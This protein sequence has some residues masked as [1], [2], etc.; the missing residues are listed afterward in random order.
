MSRPTISLAVI[1][2]DCA[3]D[4]KRM[5]DSVYEH[6]DQLVVVVDSR[7]DDKTVEVATDFTHKVGGGSEVET[8]EWKKLD[9]SAARNRSFELC[10][11]DFIIW[12]DSDDVVPD[13]QKLL[14]EI[15]RILE[16]GGV[17]LLM[18]R[19]DYEFDQSGNCT[20]R[21]W[22]E[23][24]L[25]N[26][27]FYWEDPIHE[28]I[29]SKLGYRLAKVPPNM[30]VIQH[31]RRREDEARSKASLARNLAHFEEM[32]ED[33]VEL[34]SRMKFYYANTLIG[35][36]RWREAIEVI[37]SYELD[38]KDAAREY[39]TALCNQSECYRHL[40][41]FQ[42]ALNAAK[43][44]WEFDPTRPMAFIHMAEA[45]FM[46]RDYKMAIA[47]SHEALKHAD[48]Q[49]K[50]LVYN[51]AA[52]MGR[53]HAILASCYAAMREFKKAKEH[54]EKALAVFPDDKH[55]REIMGSVEN[56]IA[57][58]EL[59]RSWD[60]ISNQLAGEHLDH[61]LTE[62]APLLPEAL[63]V[64]P[65]VQ[66]LIP[67]FR[68][69][70]P[71][72]AFLCGVASEPWGPN[73]L[74]KGIGGSEEAVI[75]I[76][77]ELRDLGWRV[78]VYC[79]TP[80]SGEHDGVFW[81]R[82]WEW[83]GDTD[84]IDVVIS[85]RN[86]SHPIERGLGAKVVY[87]WQHDIA[88]RAGWSPTWDTIYDGVILL[89]DFH[90][91]LYDFIPDEKVIRSANGIQVNESMA[92]VNDPN[93]FL[94]G[95]CPS[96][97][98]ETVLDSWPRI[99]GLNPKAELHCYYGWNNSAR[100]TAS[101]NPEFQGIINRIEE[102][103][104]QDGVHWHGRVSQSEMDAAYGACGFWLYPTEFPE[105][106]CIT[107]MKVQAYGCWPITTTKGAVDETVFAGVKVPYE[108]GSSAWK[109]A[110]EHAVEDAIK[111]PPS[112]DQRDEM[113]AEARKRFP[114]KQVA[115]QWTE[116]FVGDLT[117]YSD[118]GLKRMKP[119]DLTP[120]LD[121][122]SVEAPRFPRSVLSAEEAIS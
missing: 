45:C 92:L 63:Q 18:V 114:W 73:S 87:A 91:Y 8:F 35:K 48:N 90:R 21:H 72:I 54:G 37:D 77:R 52:I 56:E 58:G 68:D 66:R 69:E 19:Y 38:Q 28:C 14:S 11:K 105:I 20:T 82:D 17:D 25:R 43:T 30:G 107:A 109:K 7:S 60:V 39:Y 53:P 71:T 108:L 47:Q 76:S 62:I 86:P 65:G 120:T 41:E 46:A 67:R 98:L 29:Q 117:C 119:G 49:D 40:G 23:R 112:Q 44:A 78:E 31:T 26:G 79:N 61:N 121:Q 51:P 15:R 2:R 100:I 74:E 80:V 111:H 85:W 27:L 115:E 94:Y 103:R 22:R 104:Q 24:V 122:S 84:A 70:R 102:K 75:R 34:T 16:K 96:R 118:R 106:S 9:F 5:L 93:K 83:M 110:W 6:I 36:G 99:K 57:R 113:V 55:L 1:A 4:L 50:E 81:Y 12:L 59:M 10:N 88:N 97:G 89:S 32:I 13:A 116:R 42:N 101:R 95:S 33:G 64:H 3:D